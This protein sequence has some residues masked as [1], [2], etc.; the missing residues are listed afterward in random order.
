MKY[1]YKT[2][3]VAERVQA[4]RTLLTI[5][6]SDDFTRELLCSD[7][8]DFD[9]WLDYPYVIFDYDEKSITLV[10]SPIHNV[11]EFDDLDGFLGSSLRTDGVTVNPLVKTK[12]TYTMS[13]H[14]FI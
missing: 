1:L 14:K 6:W 7:L 5:C 10:S 3:S 8:G 13:K 9:D 4:V 11:T 2:K 12:H